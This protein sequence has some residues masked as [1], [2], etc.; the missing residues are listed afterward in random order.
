MA[1]TLKK[2][3][4]KAVKKPAAKTQ[5]VK[6]E[7]V[8]KKTRGR[9]KAAP[10]EEP[11]VKATRK[12][13]KAAVTV[14]N[15]AA[16]DAYADLDKILNT[17]EKEVGL[18]NFSA[19]ARVTTSTGLLTLDLVL[20]GGLCSGGWYTFFGGEQSSK[21]T[22][23]MTQLASAAVLKEIPILAYWDYEGC[24]VSDTII[25]TREGKVPLKYYIPSGI[26]LEPKSY[27]DVD[28]EVETV[29]GFVPIKKLY[30]AGKKKLSKVTLAS[31]KT[32][33][34]HGHPVLCIRSGKLEWKLME[35]LHEGDTVIVKK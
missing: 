7:P 10:V 12:T 24:I 22:L 1:I 18:S 11:V 29:N 32:L 5:A 27:I 8:E 31:G 4:T 26:E 3:T 21:S 2:P 23:A 35:N 17:V 13:K 6:T 15:E 34:G 20:S 14:D 16:F 9:K 25:N 19:S 33:L 30:Y 28:F